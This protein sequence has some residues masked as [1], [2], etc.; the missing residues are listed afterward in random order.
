MC[1]STF[2][3][4]FWSG[5][6]HSHVAD[7]DVCT[8]SCAVEWCICHHKAAHRANGGLWV[9]EVYVEIYVPVIVTV[10]RLQLRVGCMHV[11]FPGSFKVSESQRGL[12]NGNVPWLVMRLL[13]VH[14]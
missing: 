6:I 9:C 11:L 2:G 3:E 4:C 10:W 8:Y 12:H 7:K 5:A 1:L 13:A 14:H